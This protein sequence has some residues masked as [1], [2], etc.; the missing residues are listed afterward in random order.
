MKTKLPKPDQGII[1]QSLILAF[2]Y[3]AL[4]NTAI[5]IYEFNN[6]K[7]DFI[8]QFDFNQSLYVFLMIFLTFIGF[9]INNVLF[10]IYTIF[11]Y[12]TGALVSY[13]IYFM[14]ILPDYK[15][16]ET[17]FNLDSYEMV[18]IKLILWILFALA[19]CAYLLS[20]LTPKEPIA[21]SSKLLCYLFLFLAIANIITP[22]H[23]SFKH[24]LPIN[25]L[26]NA[27]EYFLSRYIS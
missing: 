20:K 17:F 16:I 18:S 23:S 3:F 22:F 7:G 19:L 10:K 9:S 12:F 5:L 24:Y 1:I 14:D 13:Y 6:I 25:Y 15:A 4:F 8:S 26:H 2:I 21:L 27:Y 11:L